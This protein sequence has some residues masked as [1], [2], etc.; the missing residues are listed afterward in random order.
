MKKQQGFTLIELMIVVAIIGILAAVAIPQYQNYISKS[1]VSRVMGEVGALRTVTETCMMDGLAD[2]ACD[3]GWND[4]NLL[5]ATLQTG[6]TATID[7]TANTASLAATFGGNSAASING[8]G[9]TWN[10]DANGTWSCSTT[11]DTKY[12]PV[13]C[14]TTAAGGTGGGTTTP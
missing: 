13:G 6:L 14:A 9:L 2:T 8:K 7:L 3:F 5:G 10:R 12:Q 4:S 1:Q 11:V